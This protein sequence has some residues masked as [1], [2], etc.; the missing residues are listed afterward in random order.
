MLTVSEY[1][2]QRFVDLGIDKAFGIPGDFPFPI[3][4][5]IEASDDLQWIGCVS[6]LNAAYSADGY[7]RMRGASFLCTTYGVG[8]LS[9]INGLMGSKAHRLPVFIVVG[10]PCRRIVHQKLS[11]YH[12]F[13]D[14]NYGD[15]EHIIESACCVKA[16]LTAENAVEEIERAIRMAL[17]KCEPA[18]ILLPQDVGL[19]PVSGTKYYRENLSSLRRMKSSGAELDAAANTIADKLNASS[20]PVLLPSTLCARLGLSSKIE[21]LINQ[22]NL[23]F[24]VAP[25]NKGFLDESS[26]QFL[27]MYSGIESTPKGVQQIVESADLIIELGSQVNEHVNTG[28]WTSRIPSSNHICI[29]DFWVQVGDHIFVDVAM[30]DLVDRLIVLLSGRINEGPICETYEFLPSGGGPSEKISSKAF[31]PRLQNMLKSGDILVIEAGSCEIPLLSMKLH[32]GVRAEAQVLWSSIGWAGPA[33]MGI[34]MENPSRRTVLVSGDGAHQETM[35]TIATMGFH[36]VKPVIFILNNGTY[37]C[38]NTI[39]KPGRNQYNDIA[40]IKYSRLPEVLGCK[41]WHCRQVATLG[42]LEDA[43]KHISNNPSQAAYIEVM[44][45]SSENVPLPKEALDMLFKLE[46]PSVSKA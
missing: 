45:P 43:I 37:G 7:A 15:H 22:L 21:R 44:I 2:V 6:E 20:S 39:W 42:E 28:F 9:T 46:T 30:E 10:S 32:K 18:Y 1:L 33:A 40:S 34:A 36:D 27:G 25:L 13:G 3:L 41:A 5:A 19:M 16:I 24:A 12:T 4:D 11:T 38:E 26:P 35:G 23:P 29:H 17:S 14:G 31:Y 8:E